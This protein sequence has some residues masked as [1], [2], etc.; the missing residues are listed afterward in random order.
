MIDRSHAYKSSYI[1]YMYGHAYNAM[2]R[3]QAAM[4]ARS[5]SEALLGTYGGGMLLRIGAPQQLPFR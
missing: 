1:I 4:L 3:W 2:T 5:G